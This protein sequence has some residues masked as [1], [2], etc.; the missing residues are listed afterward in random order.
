MGCRAHMRVDVSIQ[1]AG[2]PE[3]ADLCADGDSLQCVTHCS[4]H[5][6]WFGR[7]LVGYQLVQNHPTKLLG[8][9]RAYLAD[10]AT[11]VRGLRPQQHI[12]ALQIP[13]FAAS[14]TSA[15]GLDTLLKT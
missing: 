4:M 12:V 1:D 14:G 5:V 3:V 11:A 9:C 7:Q 10:V 8:K 15:Q 13:V 6:Q 2:Q